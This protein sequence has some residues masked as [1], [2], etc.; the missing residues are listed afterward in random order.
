MTAAEYLVIA[1][2]DN[3]FTAP[4]PP[5]PL[6]HAAGATG[7]Q[8]SKAVR[9]HKELL[10]KFQLY[11]NIDKALRNQLITA[12][13]AVFLQAIKDPT[14]GFG[15]RTCLDLLSHLRST[16]GEI[17]PEELDQITIRMSAAWHPPTAIEDLFE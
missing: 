16:Y 17:T 3:A 1:G 5:T 4:L 2:A 6:L 15:Q 7:P 10:D 14:L 12:T 8:I 13:P 9:L 11:H